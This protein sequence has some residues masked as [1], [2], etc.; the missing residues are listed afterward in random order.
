MDLGLME[1][2][3]RTQKIQIN[4]KFAFVTQSLIWALLLSATVR[5]SDS[6]LNQ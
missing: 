5:T 6:N 1:D 3:V 4:W 2:S